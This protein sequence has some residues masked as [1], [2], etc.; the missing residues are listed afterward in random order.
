MNYKL[1]VIFLLLVSILS[2]TDHQPKKTEAVEQKSSV[3]STDEV[4]EENQNEDT[5][6]E[7]ETVLNDKSAKNTTQK[8]SKAID[9]IRSEMEKTYPKMND[10]SERDEEAEQMVKNA[11]KE[12]EEAQKRAK[13]KAE[14]MLKKARENAQKTMDNAKEKADE[15]SDEMKD[16]KKKI[17]AKINEGTSS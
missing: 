14:E 13:E 11:R 5:Q 16:E 7:T 4:I 17:N 10:G 3:E 9:T 8:A 1:Y 6:T 2:C 15:A 12:A